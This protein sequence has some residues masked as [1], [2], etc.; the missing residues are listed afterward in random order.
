MNERVPTW[1]WVDALMRR[2][3][4]AG[5]FGYVAAKGDK[6]R[7]DV[8]LKIARLDGRA[9]LFV[10]S[11]LFMDSPSFD[12]LPNAGEWAEEREIDELIQRRRSYDPDLW[13]V[14]IEDREGRHFLTEFVNGE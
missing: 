13:V 10:R 14:E 11:P 2:A 4:L 1:L 8:I 12:W 7:G 6:E 5:A 3:S 9:A